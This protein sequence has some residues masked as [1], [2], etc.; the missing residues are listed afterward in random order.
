MENLLDILLFGGGYNTRLVMV[1]AALLGAAGGMVGSFAL[2]RKRALISDAISHATLPGVAIGF[3]V[4]FWLT[5]SGRNLPIIIAGAA[6]SGALGVLAVQWI[7]D[8]TRLAE[9]SAIGT[10]LSGFFAVGIVLLSWLQGLEMGGRAGL[11]G[12]LLGAVATMTVAEAELI[13]GLALAI[14]VVSLLLF[15]EFKLVCFDP[16]YA[17]SIG[18]PVRF[19]DLA[20]MGLLLILVSIGLKAVGLILVIAIVIIPPAA[21]RFWTE[22]LSVMVTIAIG[23]GAVSAYIGAGLSAAADDLPT[24]AVIVLVQGAMFAVSLLVAPNRGAIA[25]VLRT[26]SDRRAYAAGTL[27][28]PDMPDRGRYPE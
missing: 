10:V 5:G 24:G 4:A 2:L 22:R 11:Q 25:A 9:D 20:M 13:A 21:A 17:A 18:R 8:N 14:V 3:L 6:L 27:A 15:K 1:G 12:F 7:K 26:R 23:M 19:L 28:E 16:D